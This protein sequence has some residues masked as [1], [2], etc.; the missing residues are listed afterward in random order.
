MQLAELE[1]ISEM[2]AAV[3]QE[4]RKKE[5]ERAKVPWFP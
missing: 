2:A 3:E 4:E 1:A 5:A